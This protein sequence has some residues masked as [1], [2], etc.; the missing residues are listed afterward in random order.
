MASILAFLK[1]FPELIALMREL[2]DG[3]KLIAG[4][5]EEMKLDADTKEAIDEA[6]RG[7]PQK[8]EK[9]LGRRTFIE[10]SDN[11]LQNP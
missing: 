3:V 4:K 2:I 7:R 8:L 1:A 5:V 9:L 6:K 10:S 11:E